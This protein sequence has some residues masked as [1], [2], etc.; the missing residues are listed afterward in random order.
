MS[1][2]VVLILLEVCLLQPVI[3]KRV[4]G[5]LGLLRIVAKDFNP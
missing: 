5:S 3:A 1:D 2:A 4:G